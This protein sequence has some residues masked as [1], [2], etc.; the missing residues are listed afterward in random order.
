MV[1]EGFEALGVFGVV[2]K[3][4][5]RLCDFAGLVG[6]DFQKM[7]RLGVLLRH[8]TLDEGRDS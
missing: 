8:K 3:A 5:Q 4:Q 7:K 6:G 2:G 1:I